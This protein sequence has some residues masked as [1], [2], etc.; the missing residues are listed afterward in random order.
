MEG[1]QIEVDTYKRQ[2]SELQDLVILMSNSALATLDDPKKHMKIIQK[3]L[4]KFDDLLLENFK[5][6]KE[7]A[8]EKRR[9]L[10]LMEAFVELRDEQKIKEEE[11]NEF[12]EAYESQVI[13]QPPN[14]DG[15]IIL[16]ENSPSKVSVGGISDLKVC[17]DW[18]N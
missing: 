1:T 12:R 16:S 10:D 5:L 14:K 4:G 6:K 15:K 17:K 18:A 11:E 9:Y 8:C 7:L 2:A 3:S 13:L